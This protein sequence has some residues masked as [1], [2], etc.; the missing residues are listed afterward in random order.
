MPGGVAGERPMKAV[1]YA[2]LLSFLPLQ[3][4]WL[5]VESSQDHGRWGHAFLSGGGLKRATLSRRCGS[6]GPSLVRALWVVFHKTINDTPGAVGAHVNVNID[7]WFCTEAAH[8]CVLSFDDLFV[9]IEGKCCL[10]DDFTFCF[11]GVRNRVGRHCPEVMAGRIAFRGDSV[12][13]TH[14][15]AAPVRARHRLASSIHRTCPNQEM[16]ELVK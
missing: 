4:D 9:F 2:D 14:V 15:K 1:P 13:S 16:C 11:L 6:L 10:L 5:S 7:H 12:E 8:I 3:N